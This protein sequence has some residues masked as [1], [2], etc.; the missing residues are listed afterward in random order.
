MTVNSKTT[1]DR[2][3][4]EALARLARQLGATRLSLSVS[5]GCVAALLGAGAIRVRAVIGYEHETP[6]VIETAVL[7]L[8]GLD[9]EAHRPARPASPGEVRALQSDHAFYYLGTYKTVELTNANRTSRRIIHP[10]ATSR[11]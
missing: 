8:N 10:P 1:N 11:A 3:V 2:T 9:I 7:N 4:I 5:D 6:Y